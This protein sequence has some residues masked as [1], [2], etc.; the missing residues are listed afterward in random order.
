MHTHTHTLS[1]HIYL[2]LV[3]CPI[4]DWLLRTTSALK[5]LPCLSLDGLWLKVM[6]LEREAVQRFEHQ[7]SAAFR[8]PHLLPT[9]PHA[10]KVPPGPS[11]LELALGVNHYKWC[12]QQHQEEDGQGKDAGRVES[13]NV[14]AVACHVRCLKARQAA[15]NPVWAAQVLQHS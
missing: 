6:A 1:S 9:A 8:A 12:I 10:P 11:L 13:F 15:V 3:S 2:W 7:S 5:H 14:R 4:E